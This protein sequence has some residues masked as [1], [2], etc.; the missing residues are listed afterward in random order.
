M[1]ELPGWVHVYSGKVRDLYVPEGASSLADT[2][3]VLVVASDRVSAFD[4]V[5]EP[6]IPA[7]GELLTTLSLWWFDQLDDVPNHL[8]PD[9]T[10]V[11]DTVVERIPAEV[12][13]RSMLVKPLD[14]FPI[15]CVVRGYLTGSGW[16]EYRASQSVC[17]IPLPSGLQNGDRLPEPLYTPAW[18]AP[19]GQHDENISFERTVELV[20]P[21]VAEELRRLSLHV[22]ARGAAIAEAR[23]IIIADTKFEFGA[24]R[25]TGEITLADEVL[26][27]DSSRYWDASAYATGTTAEERMASFDKQIVRDWL[28]AN[29]D[30]TGT[31]PELPADIVERTAARYRELL[32]RLTGE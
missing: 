11:G 16:A 7:K 27:S 9:H 2:D 17:G 3:S 15:E 19:I 6:G 21:E 25:T 5:L 8:I 29:W 23:G 12:A 14:M 22:Y 4:H 1:S 26:T 28:A 24:D 32:E 13:G 30:K 31:P 18:K 20:G 10:L